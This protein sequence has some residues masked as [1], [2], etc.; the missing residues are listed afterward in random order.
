MA[1]TDTLDNAL[2]RQFI[3]Q[4]LRRP[5]TDGTTILLRGGTGE[6]I[7]L[8]NLLEAKGRRCSRSR[9]IPEAVFDRTLTQA[10]LEP[11]PPPASTHFLTNLQLSGYLAMPFALT[12]F[13]NDFGPQGDLLSRAP[14]SNQVFQVSLLCF[15]QD[16]GGGCQS[17]HGRKSSLPD[18]SMV[19]LFQPA[20]TSN[21]E[22]IA[23]KSG[24]ASGYGGEGP[25]GLAMALQILKK[26]NIKITEC[27][28]NQKIIQEIDASCLTRINLMKII[29]VEKRKE[30]DW[31]DYH[32]YIY[33]YDMEESDEDFCRLQS[34][35][36]LE[37]PLGIV[38]RRIFDLAI[39]FKGNS[40]AVL[41]AGYRR[42]ED[43]V[44]QR[45]GLVYE[46]GEK[47]FSKTFI[48]EDS[49]LYWENLHPTEAKGRGQ[50]FSATFM[51]YRNRRAHKE[52]QDFKE[53]SLRE[54]LLL[55][56][57][58]HLEAEAVE[59]QPNKE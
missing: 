41:M 56:E 39:Q 5:M 59:R 10:Q 55:N 27:L 25:R 58:Y 51:G 29:E 36:P 43:I 46:H 47:L 15:A 40:D 44:R 32:K 2:L 50:L 54:F 52:N 30:I 8:R 4:F 31:Y 11:T 35:F 22:T 26:H 20:C 23:I 48:K 53:S 28:V 24:F 13:Q 7:E 6:G 42:L 9:G 17:G 3:R 14:S 19:G 1:G 45:T 33:D 37:I 34:N 16:D 38:D 21:D 49:I 57:L 12:R 18:I